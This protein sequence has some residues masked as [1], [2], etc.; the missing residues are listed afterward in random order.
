VDAVF[1]TATTGLAAQVS[2]LSKSFTDPVDGQ[3][4]QRRTSLTKTIK[5]LQTS[6]VR[7]QGYVDTYKLQLQRQFA[8]MESLISNYNSIG[9]FLNNTAAAA[10]NRSK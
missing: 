7:L 9:T 8:T 4:I 3:L 10:A 2:D 6:N 5:D 1:S